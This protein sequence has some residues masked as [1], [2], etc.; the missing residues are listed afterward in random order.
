MQISQENLRRHVA[1]LASEPRPV[2]SDALRMAQAYVSGLLAEYGWGVTEHPFQAV[3]NTGLMCRGRNLIARHPRLSTGD[4]PVFCVGAHIDSR[5][6]TPGADDNASAVAALLELARLLPEIVDSTPAC[7]V[8]LIAFDMEELG[9]LGGAEHAR[10]ARGGDV[11]LR[12]MVSLEMLGYCDVRPG[13]QQMPEGLA[14]LYPTAGDFIG[15]VGNQNSLALIR[16][17][18][19]EMKSVA[20]LP[21]ECLQVEDNGLSMPPTRLSDHSPFWDAGYPALMVTDTSFFRNPHYHL[22]S[23]TLETLDFD[24]L[25]K[26]SQGCLSAVGRVLQCGFEPL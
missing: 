4:R 26:V 23:D 10:L 19:E 1:K 18:V 5:P 8:E 2:D 22:A 24:F 14:H 21:V 6:E 20:G 25:E 7:A 9:M 3:G 16:L 17:F 12:G 15:V 11:D 13:S